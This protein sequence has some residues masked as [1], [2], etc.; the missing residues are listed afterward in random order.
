MNILVVEDE[1]LALDDLLGMLQVF[2]GAH[3]IVGC[4]SGMEALACARS[5]PP[6]LILTDIRMPEV[7]GLELIRQLKAQIPQLAAIVLSG[8]S[9]FEYA[10]TGLRLGIA[11]YLLKPVRV[12]ALHQ[13]IARALDALASE[14]ARATQTHEAQLARLLLGT[15][16]AAGADTSLLAG[17]WGAIVIVCENWESPNV[18]QATSIDRDFAVRALALDRPEQ[19]EIT[20][21]DAHCRVVLVPMA[22]PE[23]HVLD[24]LAQRLHRAIL[25]VGVN[26]HTTYVFKGAGDRAERVAPAALAQ[27]AHGMLFAAP[28]F[29]RPDA[30][31]EESTVGPMREH[32]QLVARALAECKLSNAIAET[33]AAI[34]RLQHDRATQRTVTQTLQELFELIQQHTRSTSAGPQLDRDTAAAVVRSSRSYEELSAWVDAQLQPLLLRQR[35]VATPRHLVRSLVAL[36]HTSYAEDISLQAF[37]AEHNVSLAYFSRLFKDEVGMTFSDHLTR[38]R[39][40]K[41]KELLERGDLRLGD[42]SVLVG[43]DD[44]KYFS[45]IF[46][47]V[48]GMTPLDY[49][50]SR[51]REEP[52]ADQTAH[53]G[54]GR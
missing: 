24:T 43:Y 45:Q 46:R 14:R 39:V 42:V 22:G 9:D 53:A 19:C 52:Q 54:E 34:K 13:A 33:Y 4:A 28:T 36:V 49:Q 35:G 30:A 1:P 37:A 3:Q 7:D 27:L 18:W 25:A 5:T 32:I 50:R 31:P 51:R 10:R 23:L 15:L 44:P 12:E 16:P 47:K 20:D 40:E 8:Y 11:D 41:A 17:D 48:A 29:I 38:V 26:A 6:D 2:I 21:I